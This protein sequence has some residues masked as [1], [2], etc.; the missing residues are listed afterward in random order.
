MKTL[1]LAERKP[2]LEELLAWARVDAV[3]IRASDGHEYVLEQADDFEREVA[4]LGKSEEFMKFLR[5]RE[6]EQDR[7]SLDD[8][9]KTL[10]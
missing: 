5:K 8:F 9:E 7:I 10:S 1:D 3:L 6:Q 2:T 4:T